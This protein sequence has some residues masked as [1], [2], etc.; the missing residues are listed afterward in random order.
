[1]PHPLDR[2][3]PRLSDLHGSERQAALLARHDHHREEWL[4][5]RQQRGWMRR[6]VDVVSGWNAKAQSHV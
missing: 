6:V 2:S 4:R 1:M 3:P 5:T